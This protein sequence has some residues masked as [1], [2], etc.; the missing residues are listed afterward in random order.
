M[1]L[2]WLMTKAYRPLRWLQVG[3]GRL[4]RFIEFRRLLLG[5]LFHCW[6]GFQPEATSYVWSAERKTEVLLLLCMLPLAVTNLRAAHEGV[7]MCSDASLKGCGVC[8]STGLSTTG[9][10]QLLELM[11]EAEGKALRNI[12][13]RHLGEAKVYPP[14]TSHVINV[15]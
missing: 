1:L 8:E 3:A 6:K 5:I 9:A 7:V 11:D 10:Q 2:L 14:Y 4:I 13:L 12:T 15:D